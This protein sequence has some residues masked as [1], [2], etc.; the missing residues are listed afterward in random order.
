MATCLQATGHVGAH[1][2]QTDHT[3]IHTYLPAAK[4]KLVE[5]FMIEQN[6]FDVMSLRDIETPN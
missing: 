4:Y 3:K 1:P 5:S 2:A 6:T